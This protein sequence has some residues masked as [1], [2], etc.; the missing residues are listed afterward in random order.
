MAH[1][2]KEGMKNIALACKEAVEAHEEKY[3]KDFPFEPKSSWQGLSNDRIREIGDNCLENN[4]GLFN[5]IDFA[6]AIEQ[7][8]RIKNEL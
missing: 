3:G 2:T 5:W 6:R 8:L 1:L 7:A 4:N